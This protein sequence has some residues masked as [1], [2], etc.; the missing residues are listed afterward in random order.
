[1][2]DTHATTEG[3]FL[4]V[5]RN[6]KHVRYSSYFWSFSEFKDAVRNYLGEDNAKSLF[7]FFYA[8]GLEVQEYTPGEVLEVFFGG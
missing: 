2:N 3:S 5:L 4:A 1:M 6:G 7:R 8:Y